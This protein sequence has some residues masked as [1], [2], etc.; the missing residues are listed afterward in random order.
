M[1]LLL[2]RSCWMILWAAVATTASNLYA[3]PPH[4]KPVRGGNLEPAGHRVL[5]KYSETDHMPSLFSEEEETYDRYAACLAATEGLRRLRD[6]DITDEMHAATDA[7]DAKQKRKQI[8]A[9]YVQNSG[10]VLRALGMSVSEFNELGKVIAKNDRLKEKVVEQAYLYRMAA[11]IHLDRSPLP[12]KL[13]GESTG[14]EYLSNFQRDKVQLFCESMNEIERLRTGQV[15]RLKRALQVDDFPANINISDPTLLPFLNPKVRAV[16]EAFPLQA[17]SIVKK[18]GL[19]S[20]EFNE[21][22]HAS[23]SNPIFRWKVQ[24]HLKLEHNVNDDKAGE[25]AS[26]GSPAAPPSEPQS[27]VPQQRQRPS[28]AQR[29]E[30]G[31]SQGLEYPPQRTAPPQQQQRPVQQRPGPA[32]QQRPAL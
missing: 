7:E 22:L 24:K 14:K 10:K 17:E 20:E 26:A 6:R 19:N 16:V 2:R 32:F 4:R 9:Q 27:A 5:R 3:L 11:A 21:M 31:P 8:A 12:E 23:K 25:T 18:H 15:D 30:Y 29:Q 1:K 13:K 28:A